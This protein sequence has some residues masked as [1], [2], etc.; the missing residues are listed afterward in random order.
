MPQFRR[1]LVA[2]GIAAAAVLGFSAIAAADGTYTVLSCSDPT[3][4]LNGAAGW[5]MNPPVT[6]SGVASNTCLAG[7]SLNAAI[8]GPQPGGD[9]SASWQFAAPANTRIVRF[10]ATRTTTGVTQGIAPNDV[11]YVLA[12]DTGTL[13]SCLVSDTSSCVGDLSG[14]IDKQGLNAGTV[15][16]RVLC[17]NVGALCTRPLRTDFTS[18]GVGLDDPSPPGISNVRVLDDGDASGVLSVL[19]DAD[20]AGGG[21]YRALIKVDGQPFRAQALAP[22]PC[23]DA[24]PLDADPYEFT[25]PV[26]CPLAVTDAAVRVDY[27]DLAPGPHAVEID[28]EDAA[29]NATAVYG[30]VAFPKLNVEVEST[31]A[32]SVANIVNAH[33]KMWFVKN[34]GHTFTTHYGTR[35]VT[36]GVLTDKAGHGIEGARIDVYHVLHGGERR[37]VKTGLKSRAGG[38]LTLI[39]PVNVDSRHIEFDYRALR[40]GKI[41]SRQVLKLRVMRHGREFFRTT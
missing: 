24:V 22:A 20:D 1:G 14:T 26:P 35:A 31:N 17:T 10:T 30:P 32:Q 16:F 25:Q 37:L 29:G 13:E 7:G 19:F 15:G 18:L 3:G 39:L 38:K 27:H 8:A 12:T 6:G 2:A 28:V 4:T 9:A 21:V 33:L 41:T 23:T 11:E 36:R 40:P 5:I 34:H